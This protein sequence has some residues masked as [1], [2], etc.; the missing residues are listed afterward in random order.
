[1][2]VARNGNNYRYANVVLSIV[3]RGVLSRSLASRILGLSIKDIKW[4]RYANGCLS[5]LTD[6]NYYKIQI[7]G[8]LLE[9]DLQNQII[10]KK[11][12]G[13]YIE[14]CRILK[15]NPLCISMKR[16]YKSKNITETSLRQLFSSLREHSIESPFQFEKSKTL[17]HGIVCLRG[18]KNGI[19]LE[20]ILYGLFEK[21]RS[22]IV[23][24]GVV[25]GDL[26]KQNIL[27][28]RN[29]DIKLIDYDSA[30]SKD[31]QE[32]DILYYYL[33][34]SLISNKD[35]ARWYDVWYDY[36]S[37]S[38]K[39]KIKPMVKQY[40]GINIDFLWLILF[41]VMIGLNNDNL[42]FF[43]KKSLSRIVRDVIE[44]IKNEPQRF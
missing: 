31:I 17:K 24:Y 34:D 25:H 4:N 8:D 10:F 2:H 42:F 16:L 21:H 18:I 14:S 20:T 39:M 3:L 19:Q 26:H 7:V 5:I 30:S 13:E 33:I 35:G 6:D 23:H 28:D 38:S 41:V 29:G 11:T 43:H 12:L 40:I 36:F 32:I 1:M 9:K 22:D 27:F 44:E 37:D 15:K